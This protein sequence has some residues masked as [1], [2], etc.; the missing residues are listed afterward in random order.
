MKR[1]IK[2][3]ARLTSD[4]S[5]VLLT[6]LEQSH[7]RYNFSEKGQQSPEFH[8]GVFERG[9]VLLLGASN[10]N[11]LNDT[12]WVHNKFCVVIDQ[13]N[14]PIVTIST[15]MWVEVKKAIQAYNKWGESL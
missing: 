7:F 2:V 1:H 9:R 13:I 5:E 4:N 3:R 11:A 12:F 6:I 15:E 10:T 8:N 14:Y